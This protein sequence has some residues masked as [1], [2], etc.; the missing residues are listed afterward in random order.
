MGG[1]VKERGVLGPPQEEAGVRVVDTGDSIRIPPA[2]SARRTHTS[3]VLRI[4]SPARSPVASGR[5]RLVNTHRK[6]MFASSRAG[7]QREEKWRD[8]P[9]V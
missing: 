7:R 6:K 8:S 1:R 2:P 9:L 4:E 3:S 5:T